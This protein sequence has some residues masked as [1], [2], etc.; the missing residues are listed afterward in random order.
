MKVEKLVPEVYYRESRDFAYI[1]RLCEILFNY[2]KTGADCVGMNIDNENIE[3]NL[4]DLLVDTLG[5]E[6]RHDY[7]N[8]DLIVVA[9]AFSNLLKYKGTTTAIELAVRLLLN[10]QDIKNQDDFEFCKLDAEKAEIDISI[11]DALSDIVLLEDLFDYI[12]PVGVTYTFTKFS[13]NKNIKETKVNTNSQLLGITSI[14]EEDLAKA[15][16]VYAADIDI[17]IIE[18]EVVSVDTYQGPGSI[19]TGIVVSDARSKD[20]LKD[21]M[22]KTPASTADVD[23]KNK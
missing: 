11:P 12:L 8:K 15:Q 17:G 21:A 13:N 7:V 2:M 4:V 5:F 22:N 14:K 10:S 19:Y 9:S 18:S 20:D 3:G 23:E 16:S 1:G 6:L